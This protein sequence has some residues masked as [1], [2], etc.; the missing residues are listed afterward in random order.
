MVEFSRTKR[1][2]VGSDLNGFGSDKSRRY[3]L[4][5][6]RPS[7]DGKPELGTAAA[8]RQ[9]A[10]VEY[11]RKYDI[12]Y[13]GEVG[14]RWDGRRWPE[15]HLESRPTAT[16]EVRS[17]SC[18]WRRGG[19]GQG[20]ES[21]AT[22]MVELPVASTAETILGK[23][24]TWPEKK[25]NG[26]GGE[27]LQRRFPL[28]KW[29]ER[30]LIDSSKYWKQFCEDGSSYRN[31]SRP[32]FGP[33]ANGRKTSGKCRW[34]SRQWRRSDSKAFS[35]SWHGGLVSSRIAAGEMDRRSTR[36]RREKWHHRRQYRERRWSATMAVDCQQWGL[37]IGGD[38]A[39]GGV[40]QRPNW[41]RKQLDGCDE[42]QVK[43]PEK[44]TRKWKMTLQGYFNNL[45]TFSWLLPVG[46]T[47]NTIDYISLIHKMERNQSQ[48]RVK[49]KWQAIYKFYTEP[50]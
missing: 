13:I 41:R 39:V 7:A 34:L 36:D 35:S 6:S 2:R 40:R 33:K 23:G 27:I 14:S 26:G 32:E 37:S 5:R 10:R 20:L 17:V 45:T 11:G 43:N 19:T 21:T 31:S 50:L 8:Y 25:E 9:R 49:S 46:P 1:N 30:V 15:F 42:K 12:G 24:R 4:T 28:P 47:Q 44:S 22:V 3:G 48:I 38:T 18:K 16:V 29:A